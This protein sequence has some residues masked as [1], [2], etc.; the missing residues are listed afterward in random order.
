MRRDA[1]HGCGSTPFLPIRLR[2]ETKCRRIQEPQGEGFSI[3]RRLA[4]AV[5]L[6]VYKVKQFEGN[7]LQSAARQ[8][9]L[10]KSSAYGVR[11]GFGRLTS[12]WGAPL[13]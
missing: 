2:T 7:Y 13:G 10:E 9:L 6:V 1:I 8:E 3:A 12:S 4:S 11:V 5:Y